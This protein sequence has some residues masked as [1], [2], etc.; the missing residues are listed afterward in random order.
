MTPPPLQLKLPTQNSH[1]YKHQIKM[2]GVT[3]LIITAAII[4]NTDALSLAT[5]YPSGRT[6]INPVA[7]RKVAKPT[8][9]VASRY[10]S[11]F[12]DSYFFQRNCLLSLD[13]GDS[14]ERNDDDCHAV[15]VAENTAFGEFS[16]L[17]I[18][19]NITLFQGA[20]Y[21]LVL[22][23]ICFNSCE[24]IV[25]LLSN[26]YYSSILCSHFFAF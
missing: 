8:I 18:F 1:C 9:T 26:R 5:F 22:F 15:A 21:L 2:S 25:E 10:S 24:M 16:C 13:G 7:A 20:C 23:K 6:S 12:T 11:S 19:L 4:T 3:R 17:F 14:S